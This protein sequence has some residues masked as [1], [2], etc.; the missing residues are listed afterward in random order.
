MWAAHRGAILADGKAQW[1]TALEWSSGSADGAKE[2]NRCN[3]TC[4][5]AV[6]ATK[7][8]SM[9]HHGTS[10]KQRVLK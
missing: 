5:A 8:D 2:T 4:L 6:K 3:Q 10:I 7:P 1:T 9:A